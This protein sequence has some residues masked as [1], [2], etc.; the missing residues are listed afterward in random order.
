M[1][2]QD[3]PD[4]EARPVPGYEG[5][6]SVTKDGRVWS[7][8]K[9]FARTRHAGR[10]LRPGL[11]DMG[12]FIVVLAKDGKHRTHRVHRLVAQAWI[13]NPSDRPHINH[14]NGIKTDNRDVNLE[15]CTRS[16]NNLHAHTTGLNK[17]RRILG[18]EQLQSVR[19]AIASGMQG[20]AVAARFGIKQSMVSA[21]KTGKYVERKNPLIH[22][23]N[24]REI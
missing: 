18:A 11:N 8:P 16:E 4:I 21:I 22:Q 2:T 3:E 17:T 23:E 5:L 20:K 13:P 12:Y 10:W 19:A 24:Q 15:W 14:R 9:R 6:Y 1:P 7:H